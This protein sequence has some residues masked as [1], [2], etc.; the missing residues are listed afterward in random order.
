MGNHLTEMTPTASF[1]PHFQA[2]HVVVISRDLAGKTS[3]LCHLKF[4]EFVQG[5]PTKGFNTEK[6]IKSPCLKSY[7][8]FCLITHATKLSNSFEISHKLQNN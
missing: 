2:L 6:I 5:A 7:V 4:K 3:L 1:L 8:F